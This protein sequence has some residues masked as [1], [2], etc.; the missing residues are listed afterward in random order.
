MELDPKTY[1]LLDKKIKNAQTLFCEKNIDLE[2]NED[3]LVTEYFEITGG[4]T[5]L[6]NGEEKTITELQ[7]YLQD[8]DRH[9]RKKAK[10]LISETFLSVEDKLQHILNELIV[11]RDQKAKT[12]NYIIIVIICLKNMNVLIIHLK[13]AMSLPNLFVNT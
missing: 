7:S 5:A 12:F 3:K 2:V 13:T 10:T 9:I 8:P 1:S 11:I 6:W 4:L